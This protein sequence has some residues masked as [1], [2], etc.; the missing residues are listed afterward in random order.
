LSLALTNI[1]SSMT[2]CD[3]TGVPSNIFGW[4]E[5]NKL[6]T[7]YSS[8]NRPWIKGF[9]KIPPRRWYN[10]IFWWIKLGSAYYTYAYTS[11]WCFQVHYYW[12][13]FL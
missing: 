1:W 3:A 5:E 12:Q 4:H 9:S 13:D 2:K 7:S 11:D 8:I 10:S 6:S